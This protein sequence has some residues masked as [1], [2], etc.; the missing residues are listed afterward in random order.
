[1]AY[2]SVYELLREIVEKNGDRPAYRFKR[3]GAWHDVSWNEHLAMVRAVAKALM[4]LG[5]EKG[6]R[7]NIL[8]Q[9]RLEWVQSDFGITAC[10]GVT[11]GIYPSSLGPECAYVA[12]H[13][14][15]E[16]L[17]VE[18]QEQLEKILK[19]RTE[20]PA[21]KHIVRWDGPGDPANEVLGWQEF[22]EKGTAVADDDLDQ[23]AGTIRPEDLAS[24]VYTSGTTGVP[25]GVMLTHDNLLF[26]GGAVDQSLYHEPHYVTLLFLP[27]AHV[28]ARLITFVALY[29][30]LTLAFAESIQAVGEN[31]REVR[32]HFIASV[33]RVYEKVF[34]K[35]TSGVEEAGGIKEKLFN[36]AVGVGRQVSLLQQADKP[37]TG[38]LK[39]KHSLANKLVLHKIQAAMGGRLVY[40]ISGAAPLNKEIAEFFHACG[41]L[42]LEGIGMT[43]N[44]SFSNVNRIDNNKFG[45]VGQPGPGIEQK[46]AEDGEVLFR[47]RNVMKGYFKN[48]EATAETFDSDGW[49]LTGDIGEID[50]EGFLKITDRKKDL[51]VTAGGKNVAPQR[52]ERILRTSHFISQVVAV[53]DKR[54]F[55]S[56]LVTLDP[57]AMPAWAEEKKISYGD[58]SELAENPEVVKLIG[59]EIEDRN[60][61]LASFETVKTFRILPRDLSIEDGDL[62][63]TLKI[64]RKIVLGKYADLVEQLYADADQETAVPYLR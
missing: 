21:V 40:A 38:L 8:G 25:K 52:I 20:I 4:A 46:I 35:I 14:D 59:N 1:M 43:E 55:I 57:E 42:I 23:R 45:T 2:Q 56:A 48:E 13:C 6:D 58:I 16:I 11:V 9:T 36:W 3:D 64:K 27:L 37:V 31:L 41:V 62:T 54:K 50:D 47:G 44:T 63:P 33:P 19:V 28:F 10:G 61:Q 15:A 32:P 24:L 17:F 12:N 5:V 7:V 34:G 29:S 60:R 53:G 51:I 39:L 22:L 18:N 30:S 26:T 49:L